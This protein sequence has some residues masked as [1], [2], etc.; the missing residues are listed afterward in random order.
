MSD[1]NSNELDFNKNI[2]SPP[3]S[4]QNG[5][6][7]DLNDIDNA[8]EEFGDNYWMTGGGVE[9]NNESQAIYNSN[10]RHAR[11]ILIFIAIGFLIAIALPLTISK[12]TNNFNRDE[13]TTVLS[14]KVDNIPYTSQIYTEQIQ[15]LDE[16]EYT[17]LINTPGLHYLNA[18]MSGGNSIH[19]VIKTEVL[20]TD[21][22]KWSKQMLMLIRYKPSNVSNP[23]YTEHYS[24]QQIP[25]YI[26]IKQDGDN[27]QVRIENS[28]TFF[29]VPKSRCIINYYTN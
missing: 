18:E 2:T 7:C 20:R 22:F 16:R 15:R 21:E 4:S 11:K 14:I 24:A 1:I 19:S 5:H 12:I 27:W 3:H 13:W 17:Q 29:S 8:I 23:N 10:T 26:R 28:S 25:R 6:K 9:K